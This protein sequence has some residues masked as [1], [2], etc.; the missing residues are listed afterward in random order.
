MFHTNFVDKTKTHIM[1][2]VN[3]FFLSKIVPF[4]R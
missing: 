1:C 2:S 4:M 3:F